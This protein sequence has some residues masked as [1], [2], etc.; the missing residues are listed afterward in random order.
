MLHGGVVRSLASCET[1]RKVSCVFTCARML[2]AL[3]RRGPPRRRV[4]G[5]RGSCDSL[6]WLLPACLARARRRMRGQTERHAERV[7]EAPCCCTM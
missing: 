6:C 5:G 2:R 1:E 4:A 3:L 7:H